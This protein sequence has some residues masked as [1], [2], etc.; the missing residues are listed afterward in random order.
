MKEVKEWE[1]QKLE[2]VEGLNERVLVFENPVEVSL[3]I[4]SVALPLCSHTTRGK[5][6]LFCW[7]LSCGKLDS[8]QRKLSPLQTKFELNRIKVELGK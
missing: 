5:S 6:H 2:V 7:D 8:F 1:D 4:D 3:R